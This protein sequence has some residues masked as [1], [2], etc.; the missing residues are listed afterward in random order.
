MKT[1]EV[2]AAIIR[3]NDKIL[4]TQRGYG[5]FKD[6]WEFPGGK[7]EQ[8][9]TPQEALRREILEELNIEV[10]VGE[11]VHIVEYDYPNFHLNMRCYWCKVVGGKLELLEH[12]DAKWLRIEELD[13]VEWLPADVELVEQLKGKYWSKTM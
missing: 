13:G 5:K 7:V 6:G 9:E 12:E 1:V 3:D 10:E 8:G 2:A 11:L 4:A